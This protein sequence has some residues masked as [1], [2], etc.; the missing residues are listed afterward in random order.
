MI[1]S[2]QMQLVFRLAGI[3]FVL[4]IGDLVEVREA[5]ATAT[6]ACSV[7][8]AGEPMAS[9][10]LRT[11]LGLPAARPIRGPLLVLCGRSSPWVLAVD[12]VEG[13]FPGGD[14]SRRPLPALLARE[15]PETFRELAVWREEP[16]QV[17]NALHLEQLGRGA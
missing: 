17:C 15:A 12:S 1:D 16:L 13:I 5:A 10:D 2:A 6:G 8:D 3:G 14:F 4:P 11:R 9:T 7:D